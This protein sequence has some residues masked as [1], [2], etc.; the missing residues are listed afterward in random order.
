MAEHHATRSRTPESPRPVHIPEPS[1]IPVLANQMD[2]V[3][4]DTNTY[5]I[6]SDVADHDAV[7]SFFR[8]AES[9][10]APGAVEDVP[11]SENPDHRPEISL[12]QTNVSNLTTQSS[13]PDAQEAPDPPKSHT[14][15][16]SEGQTQQPQPLEHTLESGVDYQ[17]LLDTIAQS[18]STAPPTDTIPAVNA[19]PPASESHP[20]ALPSFAGLPKKPPPPEAILTQDLISQSND[21]QPGITASQLDNSQLVGNVTVQAGIQNAEAF[22][23]N[24]TNEQAVAMHMEDQQREMRLDTPPARALT[25][26]ADRP[27][28]PTT[29]AI[30]D[31]FLEDER[32]YVTEG[33]W[34]RFPAGSRLFV[35]NLPSEKVTKRDLF[36]TLR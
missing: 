5:N 24:L 10:A 19:E 4:N 30:Y 1:T 13:L 9:Q 32:R 20:I 28:T 8:E 25:S 11:D 23:T 22:A 16:E 27:W 21:S 33:I 7:A 3:F 35:G 18:A 26:S 6:P 15:L 36:S 12:E 29:Q 17:S 2:P 14:E 31:G 34:D